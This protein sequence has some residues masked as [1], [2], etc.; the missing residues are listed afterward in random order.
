MTP[1]NA[2]Q[3][4]KASPTTGQFL[5]LCKDSTPSHR[6]KTNQNFIWHNM[7]NFVSSKEWIPHSTDL[8][9]LQYSVWDTLQQLIYEGRREPFANSTLSQ[10]NAMMSP[11]DDQN[12]K[13]RIVVVKKR[14]ATAAKENGG[15]IQY[16]LLISY[17]WFGL[18]WCSGIA[19]VRAATQMIEQL[20]KI[21]LWH[22]TLF[23]LHH[24]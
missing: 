24:I 2:A 21:A 4:H 7:P 23:C 9:P 22:V 8:N 19:C 17:W 14:L 11:L 5:F 20:A 3:W 15:P 18:L 10:T 1:L 12:Q 6:M 16:F 13:S